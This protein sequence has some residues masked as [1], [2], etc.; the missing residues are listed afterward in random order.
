MRVFDRIHGAVY[1]AEEITRSALTGT[2]G[3]QKALLHPTDTPKG[4]GVFGE[5][6][7]GMRDRQQIIPTN[8]Q[9]QITAVPL[10]LQLVDLRERWER[11]KPRRFFGGCHNIKNL[12]AKPERDSQVCGSL[13]K[14]RFLIC[15]RSLP[16]S[17]GGRIGGQ[18]PQQTLHPGGFQPIVQIKSNKT[19]MSLCRG[20]NSGLLIAIKIHSLSGQHLLRGYGLGRTSF[21]L[22]RY[23]PACPGTNGHTGPHPQESTGER[24]TATHPGRFH[25]PGALMP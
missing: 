8:L 23:Q 4:A 19:R 24:C 20:H 1:L 7:L 12:F 3:A 21:M 9:E 25:R 14:L 16:C 17:Q 18:N 13:H 6:P 15:Q 11:F 10:L 5:H 2:E 22:Q